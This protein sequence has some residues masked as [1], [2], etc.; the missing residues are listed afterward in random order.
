MF[1]PLQA[2]VGLALLPM[3]WAA[4]DRAREGRGMPPRARDEDLFRYFPAAYERDS[5][6]DAPSALRIWARRLASA[7]RKIVCR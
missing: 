2:S 7:C 3:A 1:H 5:V 6:P 4:S